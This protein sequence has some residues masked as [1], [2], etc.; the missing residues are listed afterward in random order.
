M[1]KTVQVRNVPDEV[2][3]ALKAQAEEAGMS[4]SAFALRELQR[5]AEWPTAE[6]LH[7]RAAARSGRLSLQDSADIIRAERE[8]RDD[9][10]AERM[11]PHSEK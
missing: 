1:S 7:T 10:L 11:R 6:E 4:L 3:A 9:V 2:H 5:V 8:A